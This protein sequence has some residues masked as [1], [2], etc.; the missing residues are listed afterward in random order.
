V[1]GNHAYV[2][3]QGS[4]PEFTVVDISNPANPTVV[5]T[6]TNSALNGAYRTKVSGSF[7]FV[8]GSSAA[9]MSVIDISQPTKPVI[10]WSDTDQAHFW[11]T[12]GLSFDPANDYLIASSPYMQTETAP[13]YPP[14]P[15]NTG[16]ISVI[17]LEPAPISVTISALSE[18]LLVTSSTVASFQFATNN[19][20]ETVECALDGQPFGPCTSNTSQPY[21]GLMA[22]THT[23]TVEGIDPAGN[24][25]SASYSWTVQTAG[26][27][28]TGTP[29]GAGTSTTAAPVNT[30][31]PSISGGGAALQT[32]TASAGTWTGTPTPTFT[33]QWE[34]CNAEGANC[35]PIAGATG[36]TFALSADDVGLTIEVAVVATSSAGAASAT[37]AHTA[38][39]RPGPRKRAVRILKLTVA[40]AHGRY[41]VHVKLNS[42]GTLTLTLRRTTPRPVSVV[43][44]ISRG[45]PAGPSSLTL[46]FHARPGASYT[47]LATTNGGARRMSFTVRR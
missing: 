10:V 18:P 15:T 35:T 28:G 12:T 39:V 36:H 20:L 1:Q 41:A 27:S 3:D 4:G 30:S 17:T 24:T 6:I 11:R 31:P 14:F 43:E 29:A 21:T 23:F 32:L 8:S 13:L 33:Y 40:K 42:A 46:R 26:S 22:G 38:T 25:T 45:L 5:G 9:T 19:Q 37:S 44:R 16:T 47:V 7:A 34:R 2:A